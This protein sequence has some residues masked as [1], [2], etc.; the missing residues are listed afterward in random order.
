MPLGPDLCTIQALEIIQARVMVKCMDKE[1]DQKSSMLASQSPGPKEG[2][3]SARKEVF[4][5]PLAS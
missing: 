2:S 1:S 3:T 4:P 5:G